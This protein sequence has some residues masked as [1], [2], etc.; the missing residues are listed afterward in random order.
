MKVLST[1]SFLTSSVIHSHR[2]KKGNLEG[3]QVIIFFLAN[4]MD[5]D[6][7]RMQTLILGFAF[8]CFYTYHINLSVQRRG[9]ISLS[10]HQNRD[11]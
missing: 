6:E 9:K 3:I 11:T 2:H 5:Q 1:F 4:C 10:H 7:Q 8:K